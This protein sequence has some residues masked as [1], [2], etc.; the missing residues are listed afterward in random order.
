MK[1]KTLLCTAWQR[2]DKGFKIC[3]KLWNMLC[4]NQPYQMLVNVIIF[5]GKNIA[6][7]NDRRPGNFRMRLPEGSCYSPGRFS[8][9][10]YLSFYGMA[11]VLAGKE[12]IELH[13]LRRSHYAASRQ[14]HVHQIR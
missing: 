7:R 11:M 12:V 6:L 8:E 10:F 3:N 1:E 5:M 2:L 13:S 4:G 14:K 9:Y